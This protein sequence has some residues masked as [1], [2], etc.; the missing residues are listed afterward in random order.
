M[1]SFD[2]VVV[3]S[4]PGALRAAIG[5]AAKHR[6]VAVVTQLPESHLS[7]GGPV[8]GPLQ[9]WTAQDVL[10]SNSADKLRN[11]CEQADK[12]ARDLAR[13]SPGFDTTTLKALLV[14]Q[15]AAE[16][17]FLKKTLYTA[18]IA[19]GV[20]F[21]E[22]TYV[23]TILRSQSQNS[24]WGVH[25]YRAA[26][27]SF[28]FIRTPSVVIASEGFVRMFSN[29]VGRLSRTG[30]GLTAVRRAGIELNPV[31]RVAVHP[32][33]V[34][35]TSYLVPPSAWVGGAC[36]RSRSG[37]VAAAAAGDRLVDLAEVVGP[38]KAED[39]FGFGYLQFCADP[40]VADL[41]HSGSATMW[42]DIANM[43]RIDIAQDPIPVV[44]AP[45]QFRGSLLTADNEFAVR[46][47]R[48]GETINGLFAL[49]EARAQGIRLAS[50]NDTE[51]LES[52]AAQ[53]CDAAALGD[54]L[55]NGPFAAKLPEDPPQGQAEVPYIPWTE[56]LSEGRDLQYLRADLRHMMDASIHA[57]GFEPRSVDVHQLRK[58]AKS[59]V[60]NTHGHS[61]Q[62][63]NIHDD[64]RKVV[65]LDILLDLSISMAESSGQGNSYAPN[66]E[67]CA[68][69]SR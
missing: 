44:P 2:V 30:E 10:K 58:I 3:G 35:G 24:L 17:R 22:E 51:Q 41:D 39:G 13:F 42:G 60:D 59:I 20:R 62:D 21:I 6:S 8:S 31:S 47:G 66:P 40:D 67:K 34:L 61:E 69:T 33:R 36:L 15:P 46:D 64:Q 19:A 37:T 11:L 43:L 14:S 38:L 12:T 45:F 56:L 9:A 55:A 7:R 26:P 23:E 54:L 49:G 57:S 16:S 4:G 25:V 27:Q 65:E 32:L 28:E 5:A 52:T 48:T 53:M 68:A 63:G 18:A 1:L 50:P 29:G